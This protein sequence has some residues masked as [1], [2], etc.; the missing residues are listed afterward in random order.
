MA[1]SNLDAGGGDKAL[2]VTGTEA[3]FGTADGLPA[4]GGQITSAGSGSG[5]PA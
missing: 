3:A 4:P 5:P 2:L 1:D